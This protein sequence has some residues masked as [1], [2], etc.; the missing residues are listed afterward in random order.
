MAGAG[1]TLVVEA[2]DDDAIL[3]RVFGFGALFGQ[4]RLFGGSRQITLE[5][6]GAPQT[7]AA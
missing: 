6:L 4:G 5:G 2:I 3:A 1:L 7:A